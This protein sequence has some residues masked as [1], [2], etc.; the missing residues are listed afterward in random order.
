MIEALIDSFMAF[1]QE[2]AGTHEWKE[3]GHCDSWWCG[4]S[5]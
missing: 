3:G 5:H 1:I 4:C 2:Q